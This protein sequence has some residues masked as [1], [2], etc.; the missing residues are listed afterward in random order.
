MTGWAYTLGQGGRGV[1]SFLSKWQVVSPHKM[2]GSGLVCPWVNTYSLIML[3]GYCRNIA[4]I[5]S[6][7]NQQNQAKSFGYVSKTWQPT[8]QNDIFFMKVIVLGRDP[9]AEVW[10]LGRTWQKDRRRQRHEATW[11]DGWFYLNLGIFWIGYDEDT[12]WWKI[13][14]RWIY[15]IY[16]AS[17]CMIHDIPYYIPRQMHLINAGIGEYMQCMQCICMYIYIY[18]YA[19]LCRAYNLQP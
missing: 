19:N 18:I 11:S 5:I 4:K 13:N 7:Q 6:A 14:H 10:L 1:M 12:R 15:T 17:W 2:F 9:G 16:N 3:S 8:T